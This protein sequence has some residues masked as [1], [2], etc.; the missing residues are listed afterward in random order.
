M[1]DKLGSKRQEDGGT[2]RESLH[3]QILETEGL[4]NEL[5]N[6][7]S[8]FII[9]YENPLSNMGEEEWPRCEHVAH[10]P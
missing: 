5:K 6:H 7:P 4:K 3:K 8:L 9:N 2:K 10:E 1:R